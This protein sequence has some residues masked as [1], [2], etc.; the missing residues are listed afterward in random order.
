MMLT[1]HGISSAQERCLR[2]QTITAEQP[3]SVLRDFQMLLDFL[4]PN[5]VEAAG[6]YNLIHLKYIKELDLRLSR[7]LRLEMPR[8]QIKSHPYLQGLSLLL[9]ASGL[10][11]V[12][13]TGSKARLVVDPEMLVQWQ[14]LNP[15][16]QYFN[17]LE[18]W[19]RIGREQMIGE[20]DRS[21]MSLLSP[22][23][24]QWQSVRQLCQQLESKER[25]ELYAGGFRYD[26]YALALMD[27]FGLVEVEFPSGPVKP[28]HP[29]DAKNVPFGDAVFG[30]LRSQPKTLVGR[31]F[32]AEDDEDEETEHDRDEKDEDQAEW[33][34]EPP[35]FG[36]WQP[37][38]QPYFPDWRQNLEMPEVERR[39][40]TFVFRVSWG[41]VWRLIA[42][43]ADDTLDDL[44]T[45]ILRAMNFDDDHLYAF[46]FLDRLGSTTTINHPAMA[47]GPWADQ[48]RIGAL[49]LDPGQSME[50]EYDFGDQWQFDVKL[51]RIEPP[52]AKSKPARII[53]R[54]GKAPRQYPRSDEDY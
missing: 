31:D 41:K 44:L 28:W 52:T 9:R 5:G 15:T 21:W 37:L 34:L 13:G 39:E 8:P 18:A 49:P 35:D 53:E 12:D 47:S 19:L 1:D 7:P 4:Q 27:L 40:G 45:V 29:A 23:L 6:K 51:E 46:R 54:H 36:A 38:F 42:M 10:T 33:A 20:G 16:E 26:L 32:F 48:A 11:R 25:R 3:G 50:L 17:L 30:L 14:Q 24:E 2:E 22:A 43:P